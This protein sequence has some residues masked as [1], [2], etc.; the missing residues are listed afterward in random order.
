MPDIA[1]RNEPWR[2]PC[3]VL[4]L[5]LAALIAAAALLPCPDAKKHGMR[6]AL[7]LLAVETLGLA[8][9]VPFL[10]AR[11]PLVW[12]A[13]TVAAMELASIVLIALAGRGSVP[14]A[15]LLWSH[16][17]LLAFAWVLVALTHLL[18]R[19]RLRPATSQAIATIV[20]L[21]MLGQVFFANGLIEAAAS[22][23]GRMLAIGAVLWTNPW[24]IVGGS[25][26]QQDPVR[27]KDLYEWSVI[28]YYGF[29]YP[30]ATIAALWARAL[31]LTG[32]YA[33]CALL[34]HGLTW[35]LAPSDRRTAAVHAGDNNCPDQ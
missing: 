20:A 31:F 29:R 35:L 34:L 21:F 18:K 2:A 13:I 23:R 22:E 1:P 10:A 5:Y 15:G 16:L 11:V 17:F 25:I 6:L 14:L 24:L 4:A 9:A 3:A 27:S 30:G 12:A 19:L 7:C 8:V 32:V 26:L 33:A 28:E